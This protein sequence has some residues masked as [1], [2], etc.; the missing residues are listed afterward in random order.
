MVKVAGVKVKLSI[1]TSA[2]VA[3]GGGAAK[4]GWRLACM[5]TSRAAILVR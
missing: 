1:L 4:A 3:L 2:D 5:A